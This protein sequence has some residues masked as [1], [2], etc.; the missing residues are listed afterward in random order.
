MPSVPPLRI[1][2]N[3]RGAPTAQ[4]IKVQRCIIITML[5]Q[6]FVHIDDVLAAIRA[7]IQKRREL[8]D[9]A[10]ILIGEPQTLSYDTLQDKLGRL[11]HG[12]DEWTTL[13][14]PPQLAKIGAGAQV[15]ASKLPGIDE[16]FIKPW[17]VDHAADHYEL[18]ITRARELLGWEPQH[19]LADKLKTI[20][21]HLK[22]DPEK[23]YQRNKLGEPPKHMLAPSADRNPQEEK[24]FPK[25]EA[26][27]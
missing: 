19:R 9:E 8:P 17:M 20:V 14:V 25:D 7:T 18:D 4:T 2:R 15:A 24:A 16:P 10:A 5:G 3:T 13:R 23:F 26:D 12:E 11:I 1:W 6:N 27:R 21:G 22:G